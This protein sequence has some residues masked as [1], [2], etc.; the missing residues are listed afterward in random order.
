MAGQVPGQDTETPVEEPGY[1]ASIPSAV[2][3]IT[4]AQDYQA[5]LPPILAIGVSCDGPLGRGQ[6]P[7][8]VRGR[9]PGIGSFGRKGTELTGSHGQDCSQEG[10]KSFFTVPLRGL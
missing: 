7:V 4:V 1:K 3:Q 8:G 5:C 9:T 6:G 2:F 10:Y